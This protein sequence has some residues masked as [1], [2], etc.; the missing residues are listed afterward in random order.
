MGAPNSELD[1][2]EFVKPL[3]F[4]LPNDVDAAPNTDDVPVVLALATL[5]PLALVVV[6]LNAPNPLDAVVAVV[7]DEL[8]EAVPNENDGA[9]AEGCKLVAVVGVV[10]AL[11]AVDE[12]FEPKLNAGF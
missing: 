8:D 2:E 7:V 10:A 12:R 1:V 11:E 9:L 6:L 5:V 4:V 3:L